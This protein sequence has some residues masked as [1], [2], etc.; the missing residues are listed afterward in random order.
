M[1]FESEGEIIIRER[2]MEEK[3]GEKEGKLRREMK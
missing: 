1:D 3:Q 2:K